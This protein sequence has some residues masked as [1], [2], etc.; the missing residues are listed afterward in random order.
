MGASLQF[1]LDP[2]VELGGGVGHRVEDN[3]E[4]SGE[5][6]LSRCTTTVTYGGFVNA[7]PYFEDW[8]VGVGYH[9][10]YWENFAYDAFGEPENDTHQQMFG[11]VQYL[12]WDKLYIKYVLGYAI[13]HKELRN[14]TDRSDTGFEN[15]VMSHRLRLMLLY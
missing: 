10:T 12:L 13:G 14:D 3:F 4:P 8:L 5:P 7:R 1:V 11:A 2:W 6:A 15:K 9:R